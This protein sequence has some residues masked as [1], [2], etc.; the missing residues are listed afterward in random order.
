MRR[1][2][3]LVSL[4][5]LIPI[6][7]AQNGEAPRVIS[8]PDARQH[9]V[10]KSDP[11]YP[12]IAAAARV[13]GDVV[14][15]L[16]IDSKGSVASEKVFSGPAMLQQAALDAVKKWQF[17]PFMANG[18]AVPAT[19]TIAIPF[20]LEQHGPAPTADQEKA[21]Q[22]WFPLSDKC[23]SALRAGNRQDAVDLC[24]QA[25]DMSI[26]AGDL[27]SS[28]QLGRMESHE[29]YGHALLSAGEPSEALDQENLAVA[30]AKK[31]LTDRDQEYGW[32][33]FWRAIVEAH[34]GQ[35]DAALADFAVAE[36]TQRKAIQN[37][38]DMKAEYTRELAVV[39]QQH[40]ALLDL[41]GRTDEAAKVR[42]EAAAL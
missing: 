21:A 39:L 3:V 1:Y 29:S 25:L 31:C 34:L 7:N 24:K 12:P 35:D 37:L 18:V 41:M 22:A 6:S 42:A 13:Q 32:T 15:T 17:T 14:L 4:S 23:R 16:V 28:D 20:R 26:K 40:A 11:V 2:V 10:Q 38:P 27:T 9:L 30:E 36:T 33:F 8:E 5:L 19:T